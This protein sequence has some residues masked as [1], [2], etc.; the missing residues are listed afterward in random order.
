LGPYPTVA[1]NRRCSC[2]SLRPAVDATAGDT[3]KTGYDR[4]HVVDRDCHRH[5]D[6][7]GGSTTEGVR[8][9]SG[10]YGLCFAVRDP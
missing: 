9:K 5:E 3:G 2:R 8:L 1:R 10:L 6:Y 4:P 7:D